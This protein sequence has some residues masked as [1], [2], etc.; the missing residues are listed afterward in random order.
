MVTITISHFKSDH[1]TIIIEV[2]HSHLNV[3]IF[4]NWANK[5]SQTQEYLTNGIVLQNQFDDFVHRGLFR[6]FKM[7]KMSSFIQ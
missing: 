3:H 7:K 4:L 1:L 2:F 5:T 6:A